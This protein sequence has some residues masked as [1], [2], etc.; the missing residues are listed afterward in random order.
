[1][2]ETRPIQPTP[3]GALRFNTD[4]AKLEYFDGNQYVNITTDS[5]ERHTGDTRGLFG[6]GYTG[7][8]FQPVT[9][10]NVSTTGS[11]SSFGN[12]Q[13]ASRGVSALGSRTRAVFVGGY[14]PGY[15][16]R[17]QFH[18]FAHSGT[19]GTDF[20]DLT[21]GMFRPAAF[22]NETRGIITSGESPNPVPTLNNIINYITIASAGDAVDFGDQTITT[23]NGAGMASPTRGV[24]FGGAGPSPGSTNTI[25]Y[26]TIATT[27]NASDF[28]DTNQAQNTSPQAGCNATRGL[29][30]HSYDGNPGYTNAVSFITLSTLGNVQDFGDVTTG[31]S[32]GATCNSTTRV[33]FGG[34]QTP[35]R[36]NVIDYAQIMS[37]GN[38]VDFGDLE[39]TRSQLAGC[40]NGHGGLG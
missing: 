31:R 32:T 24:Y 23:R 1:M 27:G 26:V 22:S 28:G 29:L 38:F 8:L 10:I 30:I 40:S 16:N 36:Q 14:E 9:Q 18:S 7:G 6:G 25:Q 11:D 15:S 3:V 37:T 2:T 21:V 5:P 19:F 13:T 4:S 17:I 33:V 39:S 35:T 34:G 20:G 12:L